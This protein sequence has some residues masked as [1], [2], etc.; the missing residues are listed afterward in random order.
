[1]SKIFKAEVEGD[2]MYISADSQD[3]AYGKLC[4]TIGMMPRRMITF[5][6]VP[7]LPKGEE[8]MAEYG[9]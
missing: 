5:T 1:M 6:E 2:T 8:L 4:Q 7:E 9:G 3:E